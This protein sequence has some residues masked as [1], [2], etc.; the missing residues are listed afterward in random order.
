MPFQQ[1]SEQHSSEGTGL[2]LTIS[3]KL[4]EMMGGE[5]HV[6]STV[7]EG[8]VF[9]VE[10]NLPIVEGVTPSIVQPSRKIIGY[11]GERR[12]VLVADDKKANRAVLMGMLLLLGFEI[13][14]TEN[15]QEAVE[16][17]IDHQPD[18]IFLD[19]RMPVLDGF[20]ATQQIREFENSIPIIAVSASV[21]PKIQKRALDIGFTDFLIKPFQEEDLVDLLQTHLKIEWLYEEIEEEVAHQAQSERE[22]GSLV[23]PPSAEIG[24]LLEFARIGFAKEMLSELNRIEQ[25]DEKF[26]PFVNTMRQLIKEYQ[27]PKIIDLLETQ[28]QQEGSIFSPI[29]RVRRE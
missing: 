19:L 10:L 9:W 4:V 24:S 7:G 23:F 6:R 28:E 16:Q 8:S 5:L 1:V 17:A 12:T 3:R 20:G 11:K 18:I 13:L 22:H 29:F 27:F 2:G 25:Q 26:L 14:E 15:G 21:Y